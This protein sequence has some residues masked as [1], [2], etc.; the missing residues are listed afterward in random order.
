MDIKQLKEMKKMCRLTAQ[1]ISVESGVPLSTVQKIFA[2][3]VKNPREKTLKAIERV[4]ERFYPPEARP[5]MDSC[6]YS[7]SGMVP[8]M[9]A[10]LREGNLAYDYGYSDE[11]YNAGN[12][13]YAEKI[14]REYVDYEL[15]SMYREYTIDDYYDIPDDMRVELID[16]HIYNLASPS[17]THQHIVG[18][19]YRYFMNYIDQHGMNCRMFMAPVDVRLDLDNKTMIV[20]DL[21]GF[22]NYDKHADEENEGDNK[23]VTDPR[24]ENDKNVE[25]APDFVAEVVSRWSYQRDA[26]IKFMKYQN[27]GVKAYWLIDPY[28]KTVTVNDFANDTHAEYTFKDKV[29]VALT[30]G[31]LVIDFNRIMDSL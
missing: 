20:P 10:Y 27:A 4:L 5:D 18:S 29:P 28:R 26:Y 8:D 16:G 3:Q 19:I 25:G 1:D 14:G 24:L 23:K 31:E 6:A 2:G 7:Y 21:V 9:P 11:Y 15:D 17:L 13:V 30:G 12:R 22:C